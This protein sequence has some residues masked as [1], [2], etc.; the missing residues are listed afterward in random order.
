MQ[1]VLVMLDGL[2]PDA[3][4]ADTTPNLL[5]LLERGAHTLTA[6][7]VMPSITL[8]CHTS[9][10]YS[11]PPS[12]HGIVE[13]VYHPMAR[14]VT[15]L[16]EHLRL[17]NKRTTFIYNWEPL[18][19]LNRP[20]RL[21]ASYYRDQEF[22]LNADTFI[23]ETAIHHFQHG[24]TDFT[25][26]YFGTI[27]LS[28][29]IFGWMSA[30][31]LQQAGVVD[32]LLGEVL[33]AI[34]EERTVVILSDHGGHERTHGTDM[35]A[36]MTIFWGVAGPTIQQGHIIERPITLLDTAPTIATMLQVQIPP[37]WEGSAPDEVFLPH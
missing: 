25:F 2:R 29:H 31:Y 34:G 33:E 15:G 5:R 3:I 37:D 18:R 1:T 21:Y 20:E 22:T 24:G 26:V 13:N 9:I 23:A 32:K 14:P 12:R 16:V 35:Q 6:R 11:V 30:Q 7:S 36:D 10:F 28:G 8:A 4:S 17:Y 27:D 19:D